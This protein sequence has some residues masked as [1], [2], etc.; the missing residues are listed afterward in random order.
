MPDEIQLLNLET[1]NRET[2]PNL[3]E[4][5]SIVD[6]KAYVLSREVLSD[7]PDDEKLLVLLE[8]SNNLLLIEDSPKSA[9]GASESYRAI[10]IDETAKESLKKVMAPAV[11]VRK[12][13]TGRPRVYNEDMAEQIF[14]DNYADKISIK[15]ISFKRNMSPTTVQKL[16]NEYRM[17]LAEKIASNE[18]LP[19]MIAGQD[20]KLHILEWAISKTDGEKRRKFEQCYFKMSNM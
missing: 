14:S 9:D 2:R 7:V 18:N 3:F 4:M 1:V 15:K 6:G 19:D 20:D 13:S 8:G 11:R 5:L 12:E 17:S 10:L 16:L